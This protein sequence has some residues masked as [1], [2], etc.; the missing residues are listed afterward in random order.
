MVM[1]ETTVVAHVARFLASSGGQVWYN[2]RGLQPLPIATHEVAIGG[3]Y[4]D[5]LCLGADDR[6]VA[7]EA[8]RG[9][10]DLARGLGQALLY[11][12]GAH[13]SFLAA[14]ASDLV[15]IRHVAL[16]H[17]LGLLSV[18][19]DGTVTRTIADLGA[20]PRHLGEVRRELRILSERSALQVRRLGST[21]LSLNN[22]LHY[23]VPVVLVSEGSDEPTALATIGATWT[24]DPG[25]AKV[26]LHGARLLGL[27]GP[28]HRTIA[29][30]AQG[31]R[32]KAMLQELNPARVPW[33]DFWAGV[34]R[35]PTP[36]LYQAPVPGGILRFLYLQDPDVRT[37]HSL[38]HEAGGA[39]S[40]DQLMLVVLRE[41]PNI[42]LSMFCTGDGRPHLLELLQH[43][44]E[45]AAASQAT[46]PTWLLRRSTFQLKR[47]LIHVGLLATERAHSGSTA[48]YMA[49]S[50]IWRLRE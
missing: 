12:Q 49:A 40:L 45:D 47:Q 16:S 6:V 30:T 43:G 4:P 25:L 8:K 13:Q 33:R 37:L 10:G 38:L 34:T 29:L 35:R 20:E 41:A 21:A 50:D 2:R 19:A 42:A 9:G 22:P 27:V 46:L 26:Q 44:R 18:E 36:L 3:W 7:V 39:L 32:I 17:G 28:D 5:L 1:D 14:P 15:A 48:G 23:L 31:R 24:L 11:Q